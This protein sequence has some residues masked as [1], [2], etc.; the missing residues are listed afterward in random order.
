MDCLCWPE[1]FRL[2]PLVLIAGLPN[3]LHDVFVWHFV[4]NTVGRHCDE[5]VVRV[6]LE[7]DYFRVSF[8]HVG[9]ASSESKFCFWVSESSRNREPSGE[10]SDGANDKLRLL[11]RAQNTLLTLGLVLDCLSCG[12][13]VDLTPSFDNSFV[14]MQ[15]RRLVVSA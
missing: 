11:I 12:R 13:L 10:N 15:L 3:A 6:Y 14:F 5:V 9:I 8:Y 1:V 2:L 7:F 4:E